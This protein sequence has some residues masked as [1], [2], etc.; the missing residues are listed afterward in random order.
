MLMSVYIIYTNMKYT[1]QS[2]GMA[3]RLGPMYI[4]FSYIEPLGLQAKARVMLTARACVNFDAV[5]NVRER[6]EADVSTKRPEA[7]L[8]RFRVRRD[9]YILR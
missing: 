5:A 1:C 2:Y 3:T 9:A 6:R 4:Q 7:H 8:L